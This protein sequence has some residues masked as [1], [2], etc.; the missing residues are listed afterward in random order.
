MRISKYK[1]ILPALL[2]AGVL[3]SC[4][5]EEDS[6]NKIL[7]GLKKQRRNY[8]QILRLRLR[9]QGKLLRIRLTT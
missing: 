9:R 8:L 3:A 4:E 6:N 5:A 7:E 1:S 2:V